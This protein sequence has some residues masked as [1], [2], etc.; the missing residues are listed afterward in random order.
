LKVI[1]FMGFK[2]VNNILDSDMGKKIIWWKI[3]NQCGQKVKMEIV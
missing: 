1:E 2:S 3:N